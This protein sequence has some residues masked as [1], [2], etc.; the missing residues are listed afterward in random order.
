[1]IEQ[2]DDVDVNN[3]EECQVSPK[4]DADQLDNVNNNQPNDEERQSLL[5]FLKILLP[6][7]L[8]WQNWKMILLRNSLKT[9]KP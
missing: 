4:L 9:W 2:Y 1:M 6:S 7:W 8:H 5:M 3:V